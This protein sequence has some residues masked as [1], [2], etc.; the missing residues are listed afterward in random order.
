MGMSFRAVV[1]D[2]RYQ[3]LPKL[4]GPDGASTEVLENLPA[5]SRHWRPSHVPRLH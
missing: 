5:L 1:T 4:A 3:A 2:E